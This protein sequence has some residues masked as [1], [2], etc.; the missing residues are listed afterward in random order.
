ME[1]ITLFDCF[2]NR[3]SKSKRWLSLLTFCTMFF[4]GQ[5][6]FAQGSTCENPI[7]IGS[8]PYSTT[9][10]TSNYADNYDPQTATHPAC[11]GGTNGNYYHGGNDVIYSYTPTADT[12]INIRM[13][14]VVGW[15]GMFVYASCADIGVSYVA[16]S[17]SSA[18]G[19]REINELSV[20]GGQTYYILLSTWPSPQ[21]FAYTLNITENTCINSTVSYNVVSDCAN[22]AQFFVTADITSLGSATSVTV[23]DN[24]GSADQ[25]VSVTGLLTFGPYPNGTSVILTVANDQDANCVNTSSSQNQMACPPSNDNC[26]GATALDVNSGLTCDLVTAG[27]TLGATQS[28]AAT[29]CFGNP[30]DDV[31]FSFVATATSHLISISN[32]VAVSGTSTD[33]Y[34]QVL[35]GACDSTASVLCS[36]PNDNTATG[37]TPGET[38]FIRVWSYATTS[39]QTFNIC[40]KTMPPPP[41]ND[42]CSGAIALTVNP[43]MACETVTAGTTAGATQSMAATPCFGNPDDDV[44]FS[45]VAT[46]TSHPI[47]ITN[48]VA[49]MGTSTDMYFQVLSGACDST[50]S[51]LCSDPNDNTA[52]GLTPGETY[53]VRV[54]SYAATSRQNFNICIKTLPPPATNDDCTA[55]VSLPVNSDLSCGSV[56]AGT[57]LGATQSMA[58]TPCFGNPDDD[59]WFSFEATNTSHVISLLNVVAISGGTSTDM[60]FQV[61]SGACDSTA[62]L[63]CSDPNSATV[64]GLTIGETYFVRVWSYAT[65]SRQA[66]DI[67][68][69]TPPPP[70]ANDICGNAFTLTPGNNFVVSAIATTNISATNDPTDPVPTCDNFNFATN[71]KDIWYAVEVPA[72]GNITLETRG[73]GMGNITDTGI[74]VYSGACGSLT[75]LGCNTDDGDG[76]FSLLSLTG[77]TPGEILLVRVWGYNGTQGTF[78]IAAYDSSIPL[79]DIDAPTGD[80]AQTLTSGQTLAD[81]DVTGTDLTWYSDEDLTNEIEDTTEAVDATT[82]YVTQTE[83]VCTSDALAITVTVED[84][85]IACDITVNISSDGWGDVVSWQ[86]LDASGVAVLQGGDYGNGYNVTET[87]IAVNPPYTLQ[88]I[89][90]PNGLFCDNDVN[91]VV[92]IGGVVDS[93]G[94]IEDPCTGGVQDISIVADLTAC[95]PDCPAPG[96]L[97]HDALSLTSAELNWVGST[98]DATFDVKWGVEGFDVETA[99][100]LIGSIEGESTTITAE[101]DVAYE[102]YVRQD[103]S[104]SEDGFSTWAG[105]YAFTLGYCAPTTN[106]LSQSD[107]DFI[108][109]F[110]TT[111]GITN[112]TNTNSGFTTGYSNYSATHSASQAQGETLG[113]T[114]NALNTTYTRAL[115]VWVDWNNNGEFA[116]DEIMFTSGTVTGGPYTGSFVI[117]EDQELG[118]YRMRVMLKYSFGSVPTMLPCEEGYYGEVEDYTLIVVEANTDPCAN[119][120]LPNAESPQAMIVGQ[121]VADIVVTG[122]NLTFYS[123]EELTTV[124]DP[125]TV[126][127]AGSYTFFVTQTID[128]CISDAIEVVVEVTLS[129]NG[130]DMTSFKAYPN[131]VK[132]YF[133]VSYSKEITS[134]AVVNMLGQVILTK[135][136]NAH[137]TQV[138]MSNLPSGNYLV[139]VN[140]DGAIQTVKVVKQ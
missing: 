74:Q 18:A 134:V 3:T 20:T 118:S 19:D 87:H 8:L 15:T 29:P 94:I 5:I 72:S 115:R 132:D 66:F 77:L 102:F 34:F 43:A 39:R 50:A 83:G 25:Q 128:N 123:D 63:L 67:C 53:F 120:P 99:G 105:P 23:S 59:V 138:D 52:T 71:G 135:E 7:V 84:E 139:R 42:D 114:A 45:F 73:D 54:W 17:T 49:V 37:L 36:D 93:Q 40:V 31:W 79:C 88:I 9:D 103:C 112:I 82:Y 140:I 116:E 124:V 48:V 41:V 55:A 86:L 113:F 129:T 109:S 137:D 70:P 90:E 122:E 24:Q 30:D 57:T 58:A 76:N 64:N 125:T 131:P 96:Q 136:V 61:L 121:T 60:Y 106:P 32:V 4:V 117:P 104:D 10:N 80:S 56:T 78:L 26:L 97:S 111:G 22:G 12:S 91:Y 85:P 28:M 98:A 62:S 65:T 69:G 13:P 47:S 81:L 119:T 46:D 21:T 38:Y 92:T 110:V 51:V 35:S 100:T 130:F 2:K 133:N 68:I 6:G 89:H 44:W 11:T 33:M 95:I 75:S 126:L 16:C 101:M 27:T 108:N 14:D 127:E 1:R 107:G